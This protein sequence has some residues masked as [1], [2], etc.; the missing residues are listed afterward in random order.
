MQLSSHL[1][2]TI[3][4]HLVCILDQALLREVTLVG[5]EHNRD[6]VAVRQVDLW[7]Y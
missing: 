1:L 4:V 6:V 5:K 2:F 3:S 7:W